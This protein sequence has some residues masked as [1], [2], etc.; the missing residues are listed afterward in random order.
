MKTEPEQGAAS[1]L[2]QI[3]THTLEAISK[4]DLFDETTVETLRALVASGD[5]SKSQLVAKSLSPD[6]DDQGSPK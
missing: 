3:I 4:N 5:L 1:F 6:V 2:D